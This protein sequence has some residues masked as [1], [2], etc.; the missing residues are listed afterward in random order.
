M[1]KSDE[2]N[3]L[4]DDYLRKNNRDPEHYAVVKIGDMIII[5]PKMFGNEPVGSLRPE[6]LLSLE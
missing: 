3:K 4:N 5:E 6:T 1:E 2:L